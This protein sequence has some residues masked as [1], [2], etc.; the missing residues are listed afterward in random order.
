MCVIISMK[1]F[2]N[3]LLLILDIEYI[4]TCIYVAYTYIIYWLNL[5]FVKRKYGMS[6]FA[7]YLANDITLFADGYRQER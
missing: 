2:Y 7:E 1:D 6:T 4:Y 3:E 5:V